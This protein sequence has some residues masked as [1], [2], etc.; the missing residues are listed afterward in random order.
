M[1]TWGVYYDRSTIQNNMCL[2]IETQNKNAISGYSIIQKVGDIKYGPQLLKFTSNFK[3]I[4]GIQF[5]DCC[6][7]M[8]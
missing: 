8:G 3:E 5:K 4:T 6:Q 7:I 1:H 2:H